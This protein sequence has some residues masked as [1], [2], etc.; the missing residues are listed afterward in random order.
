M[1]VPSRL[2]SSEEILAHARYLDRLET[3]MPEGS[4]KKEGCRVRAEMWAVAG[5]LCARVDAL[6]GGGEDAS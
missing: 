3:E 2:L 5:H 1:S 4:V 6:F